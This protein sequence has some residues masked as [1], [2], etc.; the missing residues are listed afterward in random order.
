M[1]MA[2]FNESYIA[3]FFGFGKKKKNNE[4]DSK[5]SVDYSGK[6]T[7]IDVTSPNK[8]IFDKLENNDALT[9]E[10]LDVKSEEDL[11][12]VNL[13]FRRNSGCTSSNVDIYI[14]KGKIMNSYYH[15]TGD[16]RY[17]NDLTIVCI[18][19]MTAK[20]ESPFKGSFK[21]GSWRWFGDIVYENS[22]YEKEHGNKYYTDTDDE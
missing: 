11:D 20:R 22:E 1:P 21:E 2:I 12:K 5:K 4:T 7:R 3:E 14:I 8:S 15:L 6:Y 19:W 9:A 18:D 17:S 13:W 16:N 10:G